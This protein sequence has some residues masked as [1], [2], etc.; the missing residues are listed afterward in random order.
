MHVVAT[1][2]K[3][4]SAKQLNLDG[5]VRDTLLRDL[6]HSVHPD[7]FL[8]VYREVYDALSNSVPR[9]LAQ[10]T[11]S[12]NR[13]KQIYHYVVGVVLILISIT[14]AIILITCVHTPPN[15]HRAWRLFALPWWQIGCM[16]ILSSF[17]GYC[18]QIARRGNVQIRSWEL[19]EHS[20]DEE[21]Y[22][23]IRATPSLLTSAVHLGP[24]TSDEDDCS[25][26]SSE[27]RAIAPFADEFSDGAP[28]DPLPVPKVFG[29]ERVVI[30]PRIKALHSRLKF[31]MLGIGLLCTS[32]YSAIIFSVPGP[33]T[34][35]P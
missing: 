22:T 4:K 18:S 7:V 35:S 9:F 34:S 2:V 11:V 14:I 26:T 16:S 8:H 15:S 17:R 29:P 1:F 21:S 23:L 12:V 30:D 19:Q 27:K 31:E 28:S 5:V 20:S 32:A 6:K 24:D 33:L 13:Q 25:I 3:S 10:A